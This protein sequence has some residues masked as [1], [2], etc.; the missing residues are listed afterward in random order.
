[1]DNAYKRM[2]EF[3]KGRPH[4]PHGGFAPGRLLTDEQISEAIRRYEAGEKA[5]DIGSAFGVCKTTILNSIRGATPI[6]GR[7][8][9]CQ[10]R[11]PVEVVECEGTTMRI[12]TGCGKAK[13]ED[14]Y[15]QRQ[16]KGYRRC[17]ACVGDQR[18]HDPWNTERTTT[19]KAQRPTSAT[20][21][22][23]SAGFLEGE[24]HFATKRKCALVVHQ[25]DREPLERLQEIFGGTIVA[26]PKRYEDNPNWNRQWIWQ[27]NG[28][29][30]RGI[31][32]TVFTFLSQRRQS[33]VREGMAGWTPRRYKRLA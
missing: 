31:W 33:A 22:A 6:R 27:V 5:A 11:V 23:W 1:M 25:V 18:G 32:L 30:A 20:D 8:E 17:A 9:A 19:P 12:C 14:A 2:T 3:A 7:A 16:G 4:R 24:A 21:I 28:P 15:F 29:R 26:G 13:S 10:M